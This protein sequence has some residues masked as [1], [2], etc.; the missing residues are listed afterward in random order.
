M[1]LKVLQ[2]PG[3]PLTESDGGQMSMV[4][5]LRGPARGEL[6]GPIGAVGCPAWPSFRLCEV[7]EALG[8][9]VAPL[10]HCV[11]GAVGSAWEGGHP[12]PAF[13]SPATAFG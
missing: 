13:L 11:L 8:I 7:W 10:V 4:P 9:E 6:Q 1:L 2:C 3:W 5:R 12:A